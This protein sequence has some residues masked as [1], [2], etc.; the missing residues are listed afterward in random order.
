MS[1]SDA[2]AIK[3]MR[4]ACVDAIASNDSAAWLSAWADDAILLP[5]GQP[6][7]LGKDA[8]GEWAQRG[9]YDQVVVEEFSYDLRELEVIGDRA[10]AWGFFNG[11]VR[12]RGGGDSQTLDLKYVEILKLQSDGHWRIWRHAFNE[13]PAMAAES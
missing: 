6:A 9:F 10:W 12:P 7:V 3:R 4:D 8:I 13:N 2:E 1:S 5:P 11:T